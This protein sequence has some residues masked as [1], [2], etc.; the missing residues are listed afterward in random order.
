[1]LKAF[2][3]RE[4]LLPEKRERKKKEKPKARFWKQEEVIKN[5]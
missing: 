3:R 4:S 1:M 5:N 2:D